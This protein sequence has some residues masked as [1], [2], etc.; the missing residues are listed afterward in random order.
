MF[1]KKCGL[2]VELN[3]D[4]GYLS[5]EIGE[6]IKK[7]ENGV[8]A[9][10]MGKLILKEEKC[11]WKYSMGSN[12]YSNMSQ[13]Y[14]CKQLYSNLNSIIKWLVFSCFKENKNKK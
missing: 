8:A 11:T 10:F 13:I 2:W 3:V 6:K 14:N 1:F 12:G 9:N 7:K 4:L 5:N